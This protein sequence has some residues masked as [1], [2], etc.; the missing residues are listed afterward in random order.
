MTTL[1]SLLGIALAILG[2]VLIAWWQTRLDVEVERDKA[3]GLARTLTKERSDH[4]DALTL[5][6]ET[7][8]YWRERHAEAVARA[9]LNGASWADALNAAD[10]WQDRAAEW[11]MPELYGPRHAG[12]VAQGDSPLYE[13]TAGQW[14][15]VIEFPTGGATA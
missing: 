14:A 12:W 2:G 15:D 7:T 4:A 1:A 9:D 11:V 8:A 6:N 13:V 10:Y 3:K 5:A